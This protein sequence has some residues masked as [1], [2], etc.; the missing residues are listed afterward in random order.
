MFITAA[1][2]AC[3]QILLEEM[4]IE[5]GTNDDLAPQ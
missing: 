3:E 2:L 5:E 1:Y 4:F